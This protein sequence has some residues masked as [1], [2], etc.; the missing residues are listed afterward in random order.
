[1]KNTL[2][3]QYNKNTLTKDRSCVITYSGK[4]VILT[5]SQDANFESLIREVFHKFVSGLVKIA[6]ALKAS[7]FRKGILNMLNNRKN[8]N[9]NRDVKVN[10]IS[11][12]NG[13]TDFW[14][15]VLIQKGFR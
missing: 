1:M 4:T 11:D 6:K 3:N 13:S 14:D 9:S 15:G 12:L 8:T 5:Q 2:L 10:Q 7:K